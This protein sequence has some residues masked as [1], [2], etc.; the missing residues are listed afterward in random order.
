MAGSDS[1]LSS[2]FMNA[3]TGNKLAIARLY[4][5]AKAENIEIYPITGMGSAIF[6]GGLSPQRI[7]RFVQEFAGVRT[8]T[9]QSAFR[10][11]YPLA[12][13]NA[14]IAQLKEQLPKAKPLEISTDE[15]AILIGVAE[16][17]AEYYRHTLDNLIIDMQPIFK[18]FP[19]RRDRRQHVGVLRYSREVDG[20]ALPRAINF[21]GS[22][23]AIG[24]PAEF[25]GFGR[26]L[27][28]LNAEEL[29]VFVRHYPNMKKD[30]IE[31]A[32]YINMDALAVLAAQIV[33]FKDGASVAVTAMIDR[34]AQLR[35]FLG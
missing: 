7:D 33:K 8:V 12:T 13:V 10:Y 31:L 15:Q 21:S 11:N 22:F 18:A 24:V 16:K 25:I 20:I 29:G 32:A 4:E 34:Q 9:V 6:R 30:F 2:G 26:A 17:S 28:S 14:A 23:Y 3:I 5:F 19:K 1:A 27:A 35:H